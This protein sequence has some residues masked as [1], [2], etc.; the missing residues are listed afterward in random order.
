MSN[1]E[2][3]VR[4]KYRFPYKGN[5]T[6]EE[7]WDLKPAELD[8]VYKTLNAQKKVSEEE[9]LLATHN[10]EETDLLN[11]ID[12]VKYIYSMK[13]AEIHA[14]MVEKENKEKKQ[15]IMQIIT[16]KKDAEL[17]DMTVEQLEAMMK[18]M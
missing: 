16:E 13:T 17:H 11:K 9:S 8:V 1:F 7:L 12:I 14:K 3:A 2:V 4:K 18:T 5:I 6:V 15:R 10:P